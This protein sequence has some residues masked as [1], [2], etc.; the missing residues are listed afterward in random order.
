MTGDLG[1]KILGVHVHDFSV[2]G[3]TI[4][5]DPSDPSAPIDQDER[6]AGLVAHPPLHDSVEG[7][8]TVPWVRQKRRADSHLP[9]VLTPGRHRIR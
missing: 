9:G 8:H 3:R 7:G 5:T 2:L 6:V 4:V 1:N